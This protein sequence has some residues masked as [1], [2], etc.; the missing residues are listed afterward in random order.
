MNINKVFSGPYDLDIKSVRVDSREKAE[1]AAFFCIVGFNSDGHDYIK[2][3]V[4]NGAI[5]MVHSRDL[6][7]KLPG[8]CYVKVEDTK[9][10]LNRFLKVFSDDVTKKMNVY[11][12][13]GTNG[14]TTISYVLYSLLNH[15]EKTGYI[16][17][18]GYAY[19]GE[20]Y[21]QYHTTP[22][23]LP[24]YKIFMEMEKAD[25]KN[26][27]MEV[28]SQGLD[29]KRADSIDFNV[30]IYTNLTQEHIDY[31]KT[32]ENYYIAKRRLFELLRDDGIAVINADDPYGPRLLKETR[33]KA[34]SFGI[35]NDADYKAE[36]LKEFTDHSEFKLVC[37]GKEYSVYTNIL[38]KFNV[39][40][41][42]ACIAALAETGYKLE[43]IIPL[44]SDLPTVPGRCQMIDMGQ[45]FTVLVD[46]AHTPD[47]LLKILEYAKSITKGR[48]IAAFGT[49]G[50][51]DKAK[52]PMMGEVADRLCDE[53][54]LTCDDNHHEPLQNIL[55]G[56]ASGIKNHSHYEYDDRYDAIE[57]A[58]S[59]AKTG[60]IVCILSKGC[61]QFY[62]VGD[63]K[64]FYMGDDN[65]AR[66]LLKKRLNRED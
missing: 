36:D 31:H 19:D 22:D 1:D 10:A 61:E 45:D 57:K 24:L 25:V 8:I 17:T 44:L 23:I 6:K 37:R 65:A 51:R 59:L 5:C 42:L 49:G 14:K 62:K 20:M 40:N 39:S 28:S 29:L 3:A 46:F 2:N 53:I 66:E 34:V 13:T 11:G 60:D 4:D 16:G 27:A 12:V 15:F 63:G 43:D 30:A 9:D 54:I 64:V 38:A 18:I 58:I 32:M 47:G 55:D 26:V 35:D 33:G 56:I 21:D 48:V 52:R 41:L 7:E 50:E